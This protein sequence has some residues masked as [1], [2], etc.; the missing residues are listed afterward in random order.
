MVWKSEFQTIKMS[1]VSKGLGLSRDM[2]LVSVKFIYS[3][4]EYLL[5]TSVGQKQ[6]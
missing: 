3:L 6:T 2:I 5:F 4:H 1:T